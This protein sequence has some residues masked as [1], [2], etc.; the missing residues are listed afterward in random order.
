MCRKEVMIMAKREAGSVLQHFSWCE[1]LGSIPHTAINESIKGSW[2]QGDNAQ[3]ILQVP[4]SVSSTTE[5]GPGDPPS[6]ICHSY[7]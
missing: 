6:A 4:N 7:L 5:V 1:V 2:G 3:G